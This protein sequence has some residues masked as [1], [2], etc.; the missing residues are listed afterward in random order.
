MDDW[1]AIANWLWIGLFGL[2]KI[3]WDKQ[4]QRF[5][6]GEAKV[7]A[8]ESTIYTKADA[9]ERKESVDEALEARRQ[10]VKEIYATIAERGKI[11]EARHEKTNDKIDMLAREMNQG[12]S[13]IKTILLERR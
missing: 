13:E 5:A 3:L 11:N 1:K 2:I 12:L 8:M 7:S 9:K 4:E 6:K 10:D